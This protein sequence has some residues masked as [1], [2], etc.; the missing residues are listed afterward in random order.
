[1]RPARIDQVLHILAHKD[2]IGNHVIRMREVLMAAGF[3]SEIYSGEVHPELKNETRPIAELA[4]APVPTTASAAANS[5]WLLFHHSIGSKVA[6]V[7]LDRPEPLLIDYHNITPP[8]LIDGWAPGVLDEL[9]QGEEQ[10][11]KLAPKAF[12]GLAHS[13]FS[14][15]ELRAVGCTQTRVV[16][17]LFDIDN[18]VRPDPTVLRSLEAEKADGGRD[19][20]FVGRIS[21][22]K[23]QHD[24]VKALAATR[25]LYDPRARLHLVGTSLG[26]DYPRALERYAKRLGL[27][28]AVRMPGAVADRVLAAYYETA[29]VFVCVSDHEGFCVPLVEAMAR[30]LPVVGFAAGAVE[31]T[32]ADGGIVL[33]GKS[34]L[35]VAAAVNLIT[36]N[37]ALARHIAVSA[38]RRAAELAMPAGGERVAEAIEEAVKV[39]SET[40]IV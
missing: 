7:V 26:E 20:L 35:E 25:E 21:P 12:F 6:E 9:L 33:A 3:E 30:G 11:L 34:P 31:E 17:P 2:A 22:H 40:G 39:A 29:D 1:M 37:P 18:G 13:E 14:E 27:E 23:A 24:L 5:R 19:W 4:D 28:E 32:I 16:P 8:D 36:S 15:R 10:L 38:R